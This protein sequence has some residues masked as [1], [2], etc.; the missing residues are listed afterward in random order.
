MLRDG[1]SEYAQSLGAGAQR[2]ADEFKVTVQ[3]SLLNSSQDEMTQI[4]R[5]IA[6]NHDAILFAPSQFSEDIIDQIENSARVVGMGPRVSKDPTY[7]SVLTDNFDIGVIAAELICQTIRNDEIN[8]AIVSSEDRF[9][10]NNQ[11]INWFT[12]DL[13]KKYANL[14]VVAKEVVSSPEAAYTA[15]VKL[16]KEQPNQI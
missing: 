10:S 14:R 15:G 13:D 12:E 3:E 8:V 2:A 16:I 9:N 11:R 4:S 7:P 1:D 6:E 5:A